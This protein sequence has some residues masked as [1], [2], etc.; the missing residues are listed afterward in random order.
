MRQKGKFLPLSHSPP[1]IPAV[2]AEKE[3]KSN[4]ISRQLTGFKTSRSSVLALLQEAFLKP[5]LLQL[6]DHFLGGEIGPTHQPRY[7]AP[8]HRDPPVDFLYIENHWLGQWF[9]KAYGDEEKTLL[10]SR[11]GLP[12]APRN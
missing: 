9:K 5:F 3:R 2:P 4:A 7:A 8:F 1:C 10:E 12:T 11:G 6:V